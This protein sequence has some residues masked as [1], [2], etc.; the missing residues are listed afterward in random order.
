MQHAEI[1]YRPVAAV[2][3]EDVHP[4]VSV[5]VTDEEL[6]AGFE[7][8]AGHGTVVPGDQLESA[9]AVI[10]EQSEVGHHP[11]AAIEHEDLVFAVVVEVRRPKAVPGLKLPRSGDEVHA[12]ELH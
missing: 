12:A 11:V 8:P 2:E 1:R 4:S 3:N 6:I 9:G 7:L 10:G 5:E